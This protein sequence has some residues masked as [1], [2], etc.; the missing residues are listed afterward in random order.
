M[1][2]IK[3]EN[4]GNM[5]SDKA[6]K[7]PKCKKEKY[8]QNIVQISNNVNVNNL[9]LNSQCLIGFIL[10]IASIFLAFIGIIPLSAIIVSIIGLAKF[11]NNEHNNRWQ[12]I[13][14]LILGVIYMFVN[15]YQIG[16]LG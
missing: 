13:L 14:G 8:S 2:L 4:C 10:G 15:M 9:K 6:I 12:G 5:I 11:R 16:Y 7:C 3:C 1:A